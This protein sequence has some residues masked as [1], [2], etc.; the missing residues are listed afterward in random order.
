MS[1]HQKPLSNALRTTK[2][3]KGQ[4]AVDDTVTNTAT[5]EVFRPARTKSGKI[6]GWMNLRTGEVTE[7]SPFE[8]G[9]FQRK[10]NLSR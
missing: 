3:P 4:T 8:G 7:K 2:T 9:D 6:I 5:G 10:M 1:S